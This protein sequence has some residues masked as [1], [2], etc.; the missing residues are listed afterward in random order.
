MKYIK[1]LA[2]ILTTIGIM[3]GCV[4]GDGGLNKFMGTLNKY[5]ENKGYFT[6]VS[7]EDTK[8]IGV[9]KEALINDN[10]EIK[11]INEFGEVYQLSDVIIG[12]G[13]HKFDV[14]EPKAIEEVIISRDK[15]F[16][17]KYSKYSKKGL[18][19]GFLGFEYMSF[20]DEALLGMLAQEYNMKIVVVDTTTN[21][22]AKIDYKISD[23]KLSQ[24]MRQDIYFG[25]IDTLEYYIDRENDH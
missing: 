12:Y 5:I 17:K 1:H 18:E 4:S 24:K 10:I 11:L 15:V 2:V 22:L 7:A 25:F 13:T 21:D 16:N 3:S 6:K 9:V 23:V 14:L 19:K 20:S 8:G